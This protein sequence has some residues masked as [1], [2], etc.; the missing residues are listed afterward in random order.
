MD[1]YVFEF[2]I[3]LLAEDVC[4]LEEILKGTNYEFIYESFYKQIE[5]EFR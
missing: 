3:D 2:K 5:D 1:Q 4:E